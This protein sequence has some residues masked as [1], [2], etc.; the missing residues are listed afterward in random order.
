MIKSDAA[1]NKTSQDGGQAQD[2]IPPDES[3]S[4]A[5]YCTYEVYTQYG[6]CVRHG[7]KP[8]TAAKKHYQGNPAGGEVSEGRALSTAAGTRVKP[9]FL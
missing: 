3:S 6:H 5:T 1:S 8:A 9:D 2:E 4:E 7:K